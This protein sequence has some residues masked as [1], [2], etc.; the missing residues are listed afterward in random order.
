M[1]HK[2]LDHIKQPHCDKCGSETKLV[3]RPDLGVFVQ[4]SGVICTRSFAPIP[5]EVLHR[6]IVAFNLGVEKVI[7]HGQEETQDEKPSIN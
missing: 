4:C 1:I 7:V 2:T 3:K 6:M 5:D